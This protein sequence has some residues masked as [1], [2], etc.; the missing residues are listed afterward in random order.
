MAEER[1]EGLKGFRGKAMLQASTDFH[2]W[3]GSIFFISNIG[4]VI[5]ALAWLRF[6]SSAS[7][8]TSDKPNPLVLLIVATI[9][10]IG[11]HFFCF[12]TYRTESN[13]VLGEPKTYWPFSPVRFFLATRPD[14]KKPPPWLAPPVE[15]NEPGAY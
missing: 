12:K 15:G 4:E 9:A 5:A 2:N 1:D 11:G 13:E 14:G 3:Y 7:A 6:C 8:Y 10:L